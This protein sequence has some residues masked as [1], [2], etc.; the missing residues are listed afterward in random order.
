MNEGTYISKNSYCDENYLITFNNYYIEYVC[1]R[2]GC[3]IYK[4]KNASDYGFYSRNDS[5]CS[6][7]QMKC[8][9]KKNCGAVRCGGLKAPETPN[10]D[11][12]PGCLWW[13]TDV[14][15]DD[16]WVYDQKDYEYG[17]TC[18]KSKQ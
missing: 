1:K 16:Y 13:R 15:V 5:N 6:L 18:Y 9:L 3:R 2:Q 17:Y 14:C 4:Y 12:S 8:S 10:S 11:S 7:C